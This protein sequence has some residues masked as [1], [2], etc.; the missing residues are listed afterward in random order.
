MNRL[1][2][3]KVVLEEKVTINTILTFILGAIPAIS[4]TFFKSVYLKCEKRNVN[5]I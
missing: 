3:F 1:S 5:A 2:T 4:I